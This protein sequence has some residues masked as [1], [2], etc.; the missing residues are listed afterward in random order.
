MVLQ[1]RPECC[2]E[3]AVIEHFPHGALPVIGGARGL[4]GQTYES[5][6]EP[7]PGRYIFAN[8]EQCGRYALFGAFRDEP[9]GS[10]A[11]SCV[12]DCVWEGVGEYYAGCQWQGWEEAVYPS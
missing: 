7:A 2:R 11:S 10:A 1:N 4:S 5:L 6:H 12:A 9:Q 8:D 3:D